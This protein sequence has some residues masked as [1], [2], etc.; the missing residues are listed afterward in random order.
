MSKTTEALA[1]Q[2]VESLRQHVERATAPLLVR[3]AKM[4]ELQAATQAAQTALTTLQAE[5]QQLRQ[6]KPLQGEKG[7]PGPAGQPGPQGERGDPG[8]E[9][10]PG[11]DGR[12]GEPGRDALQIDVLETVDPQR[13]YARGTFAHYRGGIVHA[14]RTTEP[15]PADGDMAAAGW[16]VIL[17]GV[18]GLAVQLADDLRTVSVGLAH[19]DGST[20]TKTVQVP[21]MIYRGIW[22]EEDAAAG[23]YTAGDVVTLGGSTWVA[24]TATTEKPADGATSWQLAV[25]KGRDGRDGL[26]GEKGERGAEGRPGQD[27][28]QLGPNGGKW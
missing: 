2:V 12:D 20:T 16:R 26:R 10:Q 27:A 14:V 5:V 17:N 11:R 24:R 22:R 1:S 6:Q 25:K 21:A 18:H 4:E 19:T 28:T 3:I 8:A 9:G 13:R 7:E 15:L 23:A